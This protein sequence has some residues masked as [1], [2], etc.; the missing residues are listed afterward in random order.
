MNTQLYKLLSELIAV[1]SFS[2]EEDK[3]SS[4]MKKQLSGYGIPVQEAGNNVWAVNKHFAEGKYTVLLNS[5]LDTVRPVD[6]WTKEPHQPVVEDGKLFGLGSND[7]GG[8]LICLLNVFIRLREEDMPFNLIFCASA[9]EEN[10]GKKG[11]EWVRD[12][13]PKIDLVIVGE[14]T[15]MQLAV[16]EKGLLVIDAVAKGVAGHAA[17]STGENAILK[18]LADIQVLSGFQFPKVSDALGPVHINVTTINAGKQHNVI[19]DSCTFTIDVRL[20]ECYSHQEVLETLQKEVKAELTPRSLRLKPSSIAMDHPLV[21]CAQ[22]LGMKTFG[23]PTMS[24][25]ALMPWTSVKLGPGKSERSHTADEFIYLH[26]LEEGAEGY[27]Q[28][29]KRFADEIMG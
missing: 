15:E 29:L 16:A 28:L 11:M 1:P 9:E 24:D 13:L 6:G 10:S 14:P 20:N 27:Y 18:A 8:A 17:R 22:E 7:A 19:P 3:A 4:W 2:G 26:E 21:K 5:H 23:S 25:Q 12:Y